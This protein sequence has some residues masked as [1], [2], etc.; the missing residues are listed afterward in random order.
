MSRVSVFKNTFPTQ[1]VSV[2]IRHRELPNTPTTMLTSQEGTNTAVSLQGDDALT[3]V[4]IL[5]QVGRPV[6]IG[7]SCLIQ[8]HRHSRPRTW[9]LT[10]G[11]RVSASF[12]ESAAHRPSYH[13]LAYCRRISQRRAISRSLLG[14][15]QT[16]G[17]AAIMGIVYA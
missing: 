8:L 9:G 2:N 14:G 17:K 16:S 5:D 13:V 10:S 15:L 12:G 11:E 3:L 7:A 4:D 1:L 6:V